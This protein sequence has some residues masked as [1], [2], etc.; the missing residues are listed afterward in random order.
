MKALLGLR[1][2]GRSDLEVLIEEAAGYRRRLTRGEG[3]STVLSQRVVANLFF[4]PATRTRL[5]CQLAARRLGAEVL[6]LDPERSSTTKGESLRDTAR[7]LA[8]MG[9][10]ILVVRHSEEG[11]PESIQHWTGLAVVNAG[12]GTGEH[13]TQALADALALSLRFGGI[14]GIRMGIVGDIRHSRVA[15]SLVSAM[16]ALGVEL[17]LVGPPDLLPPSPPPELEVTTDLDEALPSLDVVYLL[18]VQRERGGRVG[19]DYHRQ[20]GMT[21]ERTQ[22]LRA[23][24]VIMHPGPINRG[25]EISPEVADGPRSLILEQVACGVPVRMAVLAAVGEGSG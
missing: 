24:G 10:D 20:Y 22:R 23:E 7:T 1:G 2:M 18:R 25:V 16:P 5:S 17:M 12:D 9:S 6:T 14:E 8:A 3:W 15:S 4:E 21:P 11:V 19:D 13:P